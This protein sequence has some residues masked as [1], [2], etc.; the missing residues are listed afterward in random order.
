MPRVKLQT[1][2]ASVLAAAF[3]ASLASVSPDLHVATLTLGVLATVAVGFNENIAYPGVTLI[4]DACDIG[5]ASGALGSIRAMGGAIAQALYVSILNNRLAQNIETRVVPAAIEAGLPGSSVA[6]LLEAVTV[7]NISNVPGATEAVVDMVMGGIQD[8]YVSSFRVVF[9]ATI[10]FGV[11]L[12]VF[13]F[14]VPDM[15]KYLSGNVARRLQSGR[16]SST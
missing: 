8:S 13:A 2:I 16:S 15:E 11:L 5:L 3:V 7:G 6:A 12:I 9:Y 4:F 10:P 14:F 1:V